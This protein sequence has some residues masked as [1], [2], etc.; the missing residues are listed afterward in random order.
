MAGCG[1]PE[2][3]RMSS[4]LRIPPW[5]AVCAWRGAQPNGNRAS[6][7]S[8]LSRKAILAPANDRLAGIFEGPQRF[9]GVRLA[10]VARYAGVENRSARKPQLVLEERDK[11][12][13]RDRVPLRLRIKSD[14]TRMVLAV[15]GDDHIGLGRNR[16][17]RSIRAGTARAEPANHN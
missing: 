16:R 13:A 8:S 14:D 11:I 1:L 9:G 2:A 15:E 3:Q 10:C 17:R 4:P 7:E 12:G 5:L 6:D